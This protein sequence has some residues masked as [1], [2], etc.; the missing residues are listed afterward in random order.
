MDSGGGLREETF[1]RRG[2]ENAENAENAELSRVKQRGIDLG[3]SQSGNMYHQSSD[4]FEA[5]CVLSAS[6]V[7]APRFH[8]PSSI[9]FLQQ[10]QPRLFFCCAQL[11]GHLVFKLVGWRRARLGA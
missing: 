4:V 6:A 2:A 11:A 9:H 1:Y 8:L 7:E 5:L 3:Q 10:A